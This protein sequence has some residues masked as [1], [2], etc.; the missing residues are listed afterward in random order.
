MDEPKK[1]RKR[2]S[3]LPEGIY[4]QVVP[5]GKTPVNT[6]VILGHRLMWNFLKK[7]GVSRRVYNYIRSEGIL[8][9]SNPA[10]KV[11]CAFRFERDSL[12]IADMEFRMI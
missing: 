5:E 11:R 7:D 4:E 8:Y 10:D 9:L 1:T 3:M 2:L 6:V 12:W